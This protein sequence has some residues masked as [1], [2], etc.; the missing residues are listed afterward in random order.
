MVFSPNF[1]LYFT[2]LLNFSLMFLVNNLNF[3]IITSHS[4]NMTNLIVLTV[5]SAAVEHVGLLAIHM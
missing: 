5:C 1:S 2:G 3:N 4:V